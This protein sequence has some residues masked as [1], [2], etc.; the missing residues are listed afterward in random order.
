[1]LIEIFLFGVTV[2]LSY[3]VYKLS[4]VD[5]LYFEKRNLK[6][7]T[8]SYSVCTLFKMATG[9][10]TAAEAAQRSYTAFPNES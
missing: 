7:R 3:I 4:K 9:Q 2:I 1:M 8:L 6:Y 10:F 5:R